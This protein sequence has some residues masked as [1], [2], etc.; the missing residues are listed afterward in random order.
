MLEPFEIPLTEKQ[1]MQ[2]KPFKVHL[3]M[4]INAPLGSLTWFQVITV[5][6]N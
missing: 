4:S 3:E 5:I 2:R 1:Q 6:N